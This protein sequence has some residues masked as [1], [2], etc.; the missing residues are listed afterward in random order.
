MKY[1]SPEPFAVPPKLL[2]AFNHR[3][4]ETT[5]NNIT[6]QDSGNRTETNS[7]IAENQGNTTVT[8]G[9]GSGSDWVDKLLPV[10][11]IVFLVVAGLMA[12]GR[13]SK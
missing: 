8:L 4:Q 13:E 7:Q 5:T 3:T 6:N 12:L 10:V 1:A 9:G 11:A 2:D